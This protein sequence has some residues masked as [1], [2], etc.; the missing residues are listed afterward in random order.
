MALGF[1]TLGVGA[2]WAGITLE[3]MSGWGTYT[4]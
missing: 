2:F 1:R 4:A 3:I